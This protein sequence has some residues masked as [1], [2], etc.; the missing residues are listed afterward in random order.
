MALLGLGQR[1]GHPYVAQ[2]DDLHAQSA[3]ALLA[4]RF[5]STDI[6]YLAL[7]D[8]GEV[9][10]QRWAGVERETPIGSLI[11]PFLAVAYGETHLSFPKFHCSGK[12]TCWL[13]RGH[14]ALEIREA[15]AYS[16][17]SYFHQLVASAGAG[18]AASTLDSFALSATDASGRDQVPVFEAGRDWK[19]A[20]LALTRAYLELSQ[21]AS[22]KAVALVLE[23]MELSAQKGTAKAAGIALQHLPVLAKTGTA[24]CTHRKKAPG[25]G[26]ALL[27]APA[28]HP[29]VV[30]LVR[31]H[32]RPGAIAAG[33]AGRMVADL[34]SGNPAR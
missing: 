14:G 28:D 7:N 4:H 6:S 8:K 31:L 22:E 30:L 16:C 13:P 17:N 32:G 19:A 23:G 25:D 1:T 21:R 3:S 34:E 15:I 24:A 5:P 27:M 10:A 12:K 9:I 2:A 18:F 26:F 33:V 29:R 20:P 11:K